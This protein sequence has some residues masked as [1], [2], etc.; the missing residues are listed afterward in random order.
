MHNFALSRCTKVIQ[1][2]TVAGALVNTFTRVGV[3]KN[4]ERSGKSV[5]VNSHEG[6]VQTIV[7]EA[8]SHNSV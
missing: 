6:D 8:V 4:F 3:P 1:A 2:E 5:S 7:F